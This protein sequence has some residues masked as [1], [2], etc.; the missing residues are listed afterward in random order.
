MLTHYKKNALHL[1]MVCVLLTPAALLEAGTLVNNSDQTVNPK[2]KC[3]TF[4]KVE[5]SHMINF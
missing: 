2:L 4:T 5:M 1:A 3:H